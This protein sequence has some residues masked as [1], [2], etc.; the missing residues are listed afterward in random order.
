MEGTTVKRLAI[1]GAGGHAV[2]AIMEVMLKETG[3][4]KY[5]PEALL[6]KMV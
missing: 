2:L 4:V 1:I 3:N 5:K 6:K